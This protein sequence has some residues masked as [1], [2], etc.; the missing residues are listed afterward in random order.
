MF[1][2]GH[3]RTMANLREK[4]IRSLTTIKINIPVSLEAVTLLAALLTPIK[5]MG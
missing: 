5:L 1:F 3:K 4:V 2:T